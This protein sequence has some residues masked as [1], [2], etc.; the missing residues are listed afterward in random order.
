[1]IKVLNLYAGIGG[2]RK[3]WKNVQV[4]AVELD[5]DIA[6]VYAHFYPDDELIIG[7][8]HNYLLK[9]Y[10]RFDFIW[11]SPP[12]PTH[13]DMRRVTVQSGRYPAVYPD[14]SLWQEI[15]LLRYFAP[16]TSR[17]AIE[18]VVSYYQP[19]VNPSFKLDR[20]CFWTNFQA[21]P[22]EF[23]ARGIPLEKINGSNHVIYGFDLAKIMLRDKRRV[24]RNL[25]NPEVG[26][27]VFETAMGTVRNEDQ[28]GLFA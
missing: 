7:D 24:L 1:M 13:S 16:K 10:D 12:C 14:L 9:N 21:I 20:H 26:K 6:R 5:P 28:L 3:L 25:V 11:S 2:N 23:E 8:A 15:T 22:K 17:W 19:I 27:Y 18:N 4:T